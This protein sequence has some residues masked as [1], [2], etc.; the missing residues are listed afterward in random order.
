MNG[1]EKILLV[2]DDMNLLEVSSVLGQGTTFDVFLPAC[3]N[4]GS[5]AEAQSRS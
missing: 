2:D 5:V 3:P 4:D 1:P